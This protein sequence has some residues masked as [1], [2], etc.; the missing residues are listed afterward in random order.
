[1]ASGFGNPYGVRDATMR[2]GTTK[3]WKLKNITP[4]IMSFVLVLIAISGSISSCSKSVTKI[5]GSLIGL[6]ANVVEELRISLGK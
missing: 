1:M 2:W 6:P 5:D 4:I 3:S